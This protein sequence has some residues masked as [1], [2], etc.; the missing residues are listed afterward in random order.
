MSDNTHTLTNI[1]RRRL[2]DRRMQAFR[3]SELYSAKDLAFTFEARSFGSTLRMT[4][5]GLLT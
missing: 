1:P 3:H 5:F 2:E 4:A